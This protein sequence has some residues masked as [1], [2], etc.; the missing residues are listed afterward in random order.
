[1]VRG[2]GSG[3]ALTCTDASIEN[4]AV[5]E[6]RILDPTQDDAC[7][8]LPIAGPDGAEHLY[9]PVATEGQETENGVSTPY[10][11]TGSSPAVAALQPL[12]FGL[13]SAFRPPPSA[14]EFHRML[15][16]RERQLTE[17]TAE[18]ALQQRTEVVGECTAPGSARRAAHF[19]GLQ[20][21]TMQ[22]LY[23]CRRHRQGSRD[24]V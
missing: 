6:H 15:R 19:Q 1:M 7:V 22:R 9:V 3:A 2:P 16:S 18:V 4:L 12:S 24:S 20:Q 11:I 5:G 17:G 8:R 21:Q 13:V 10:S 23:R 14:N